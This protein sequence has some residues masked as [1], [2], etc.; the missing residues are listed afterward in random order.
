MNH[1]RLRVSPEFVTGLLK[2][3]A[4]VSI[5]GCRF[6]EDGMLELLVSGDP[7]PAKEHDAAPL[8]QAT[9]TAE[10]PPEQRVMRFVSFDIR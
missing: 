1:G 7:V 6:T 8:I 9:Y 4:G 5:N 10:G 3:P 2:F